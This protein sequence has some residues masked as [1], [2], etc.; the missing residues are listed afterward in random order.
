M[1]ALCT[2]TRTPLRSAKGLQCNAVVYGSH[3]V[4]GVAV[5]LITYAG[6]GRAATGAT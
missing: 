6:H 3:N 5:L 2:F 1:A 4:S